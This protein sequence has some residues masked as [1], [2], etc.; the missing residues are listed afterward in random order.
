MPSSRQ[1]APDDVPEAI[2]VYLTTGRV[3][4]GL[5]GKWDL[6]ECL[7]GPLGSTRDELKNWDVDAALEPHRARLRAEGVQLFEGELEDRD[8]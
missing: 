5:D 7:H 8:E 3:D 1:T 2:R 4:N 6:F